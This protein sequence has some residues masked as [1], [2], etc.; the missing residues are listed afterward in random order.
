MTGKIGKVKDSLQ[1]ARSGKLVFLSH[2]ILN[3]NACVRGLASQ[4]AV[5][6]ELVDLALDNDVAMYQMP[7]PEVTYLGSMRWGQVKKMYGNP[8][9]RRHCR[10]IAEQICDQVQTYRDNDHKVLGI[11][12]RDGSPTCGLKCSAVEA[13]SSQVWGGMVWNA[14]PL[15]CFGETEGVFTEELKAE[16]Q[17][18]NIEDLQLLSLPE[19]PEAGSLED[20]L[21]QIGVVFQEEASQ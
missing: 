8:M 21:Q 1:D 19:V 9:F 15:Q 16:L 12:F 4:P 2:C 6:R 20:A 7:C 17:H 10:K 13:D 11:V 14:S 3:Q 5:I 18:R